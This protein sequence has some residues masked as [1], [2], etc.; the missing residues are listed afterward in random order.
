MQLGKHT[1]ALELRLSKDT[2]SAANKLSAAWLL[3]QSVS[4]L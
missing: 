3:G 4:S 2:C 1:T